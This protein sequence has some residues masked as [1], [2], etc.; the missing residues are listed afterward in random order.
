MRL[1]TTHT[2]AELELSPA[3]YDE[4]KQKLLDADYGHAIMEDGTVDMSGIGVTRGPELESISAADVGDAK[5]LLG[6]D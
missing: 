4:I 3:A 1:R 5:G 2:I 6:E